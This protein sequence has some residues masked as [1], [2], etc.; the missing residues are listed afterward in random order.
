MSSTE[1]VMSLFGQWRQ[2][3]CEEGAFIEAREWSHVEKCQITKS[4][5][6]LRILKVSGGI[7]EEQFRPI[8][9]ALIDLERRNASRLREQQD[10]AECEKV[11]LD[12]SVRNLRQIHRSYVPPF[13]T[14]WQSYS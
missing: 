13:P 8:I 1:E 10:Q 9:E 14:N 12:K 6:Q 7:Y 3:S 4:H 2:L 5:L 11:A